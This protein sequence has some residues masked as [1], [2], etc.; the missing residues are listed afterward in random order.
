[1][2]IGF[3]CIVRFSTISNKSLYETKLG[4][5]EKFIVL[6]K[7]VLSPNDNLRD[8]LNNAMDDPESN[9][10]CSKYY[11]PYEVT[12]LSENSNK[13]RS[14]FHL[15]IS[16]LPFHIEELSTLITEHS[17]NLEL[18]AKTDTC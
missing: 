9:M 12:P 7:K 6:T 18:L 13:H 1:M 4:K 15:N 10:V 14:F 11:E 2:I 16:S 3:K 5:K 17:F 8:K